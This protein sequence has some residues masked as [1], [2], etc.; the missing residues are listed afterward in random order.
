[1]IAMSRFRTEPT[2]V[3]MDSDAWEVPFRLS[4]EDLYL[5]AGSDRREG[6][7]LLED[8]EDDR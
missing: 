1:M 8:R 4:A 3:L 2:P 7:H 6:R 5:E